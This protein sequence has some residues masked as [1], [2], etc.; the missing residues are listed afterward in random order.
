MIAEETADKTDLVTDKE[1]ETQT[2]EARPNHEASIEPSEFV[3]GERKGQG[4]RGGNQHHSRDGAGTENQQ[5][6]NC[7][8]RITNRA[9]HQQ[10]HRGG[11]CQ[12]VD[13]ADEQRAQRVK[14]TQLP[15]RSTQPIRR[16]ETIAMMIRGRG[17]GVPVKMHV[18]TVFVEVGMFASRAWVRR[19]EFFA[20]PFHRAGEVQ[21]AEQNQHQPHGKFHGQAGT[22]RNGQ[23]K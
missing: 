15:N 21:H 4:E 23:A 20:D 8:S 2:E 12:A 5:V 6:K 14:K 10:S 11:T 16:R 17:V 3:T 9:Q 7:P 19:G 18:G 13:D 1:P 22:R